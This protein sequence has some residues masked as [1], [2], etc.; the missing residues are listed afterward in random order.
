[1]EVKRVLGPLAQRGQGY[2]QLDKI[3]KN[4]VNLV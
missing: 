4:E 2:K 1:V 3:D